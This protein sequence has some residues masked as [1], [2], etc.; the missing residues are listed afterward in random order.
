MRL[1]RVLSVLGCLLCAITAALPVAAQFITHGP[2][3][4]A[5]GPD[6]A[7]VYIRT[8]QATVFTAEVSTSPSFSN[9]IAFASQTLA[10]KDSSAV[11][12]LRGLMPATRYYVRFVFTG[13][14]DTITG[15][16]RTFP[17]V[18]QKGNYVF[19]VGSCQ[20]SANMKTFLEIP[21][22]NPDLFL[23]LGDW[24]Y[25]SYQLPD[26]LYPEN[27]SVLNLA[28]RRRYQE[29]N[30]DRMLRN[31]PVDYVHDDD[32]FFEGGSVRNY[33]TNVDLNNKRFID[34]PV[35][36]S[37]RQRCIGAYVDY[38]PHYNLVDTSEGLYHSFRF[39]NVEV[40][41]LDVRSTSTP[42]SWGFTL[43]SAANRWSF[44]PNANPSHTLLRP[45]Q[46]QWLLNGLKNSTA[47][48][49]LL[50]SGAVFN[51]K[52]R[53][54]I[55]LGIQFQDLSVPGQGNGFRL[56]TAFSGEWPGYPDQRIL[57]DYLATEGIKD[58][59]IV[60][61][62]SHVNMVDDG[63]NAGIPEINA[64]GLAV[65]DGDKTLWSSLQTLG[66][67]FGVPAVLDSLWNGGGTGIGLGAGNQKN[68]FGKVEFFESDSVRLSVVDEDGGLMGTVTVLHSSRVTGVSNSQ[69]PSPLQVVYP[70]PTQ[71]ELRVQFRPGFVAQ[72]GDYIRVLD[73]TGR[74]VLQRPLAL[75][76]PGAEWVLDVSALAPGLYFLAVST[77]QGAYADRF[78]KQ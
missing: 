66:T 14:T 5:L 59:L 29:V 16:F 10:D 55:D 17:T 39:G 24:T 53:R 32:D 76:A 78:V 43:D 19:A 77:S 75:H 8:H 31:L 54:Y 52:Q 60:S 42:L 1:F 41:F 73:A 23:H 63:T 34:T 46:L 37:L 18:G 61:G 11:V 71:A 12:A 21:R 69:A 9:P 48:W 56:A 68:G 3:F 47:D 67:L 62:Q 72:P 58:V 51:V 4:G 15:S 13:G 38:F 35:P 50:C 6:S 36:D 26:P 30:M 45:A 25:P 2:V 64:S 74:E 20:E 22:H 57:L 70:S 27:D 44:T 49:K 7:R 33:Y 28:W 40:F 65:A